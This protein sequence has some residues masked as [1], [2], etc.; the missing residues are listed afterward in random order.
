MNSAGTLVVFIV[1]IR[2]A[3]LLDT[4]QRHA[5]GVLL[6]GRL[7]YHSAASRKV[8]SNAR[9]LSLRHQLQ[10]YCASFTSA[11]TSMI[12]ATRPSPMIVAPE[13]PGTLR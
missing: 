5:L 10:I 3:Q 6:L 2:A 13:M 1:S 11:P 7:D 9:A 4:G 12:M 8:P